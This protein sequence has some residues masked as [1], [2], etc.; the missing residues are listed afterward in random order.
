MLLI[1]DTY[2]RHNVTNF[3]KLYR[4]LIH[5]TGLLLI[6]ALV[7]FFFVFRYK[8]KKEVGVLIVLL[9][10]LFCEL[11]AYYLKISGRPNN[12]WIYNVLIPIQQ[13]IILYLFALNTTKIRYKKA[14]MILTLSC[15]IASICNLRYGQGLHILNTYNLVF[16][17]FFV[18]I[19]SYL[20]LRQSIFDMSF[21]SNSLGG[22]QVGSLIYYSISISV[23]T[24]MPILVAFDIQM[25]K[26]FFNI[27][28]SAY[29]LWAG[30][31]LLGFI[32]LK[33]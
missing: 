29:F 4:F 33:R 11:I 26:F 24:A 16:F 30:F 31:I 7:A 22:L 27:N 25:A 21:F 2:V 28:T 12:T 10:T 13:A 6:T 5:P 32:W 23:L 19:L 1:L 18:A 17:G 20:S 14:S 15:I 3:A 8:N 9:T